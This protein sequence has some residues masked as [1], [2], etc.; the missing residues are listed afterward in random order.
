MTELG[1]QQ[2]ETVIETMKMKRFHKESFTLDIYG[3]C[4]TCNAKLNRKRKKIKEAEAKSAQKTVG[5][6]TPASE[7]SKAKSNN[8]N[9]PVK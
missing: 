9:K 8:N 5:G 6:K 3:I 2:V 4:S 1:T 7:K